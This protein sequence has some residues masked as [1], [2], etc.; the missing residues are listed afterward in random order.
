[1]PKGHFE[2]LRKGGN[3]SAFDWQAQGGRLEGAN[4][5]Q[6]AG[7]AYVI[8]AQL[9][10]PYTNWC[11]AARMY[12]MVPQPD[13]ILSSARSCITGGTGKDKS[14]GYLAIA[15]RQIADV[16]CDRGVY[17]EALSHAKE[18][19]VLDSSYSWAYASMADALYG[20]RR[21]QE[22]VNAE[23]EAIRLSDGKYASMHF[24]LGNAYFAT[25]NW[26]FARQSFEKAAE[27]APK[28]PAS[29]YN[30]GLCLQRLGLNMDAAHWFEEVLRRDP[31]WSD[32]DDLLNKIRI[33]KQ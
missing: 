20:L 1:L 33:L 5:Y 28:D 11:D 14:E 18:A 32:R 21:F 7:D 27:L 10:A 8:A 22:T 4:E 6:I 2:L 30:V 23:K 26:E 15:H 24:R 17:E 31:N 3:A 12:S 13:S 29:A 16:L 9:G 25:E 19:T